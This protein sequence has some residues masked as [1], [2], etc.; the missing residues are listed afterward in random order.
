MLPIGNNNLQ[1]ASL[2]QKPDRYGNISTADTGQSR[3]LAGKVSASDIDLPTSR[4]RAGEMAILPTP[5][6]LWYVSR[7]IPCY[8]IP[9]VYRLNAVSHR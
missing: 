9:L 8:D 4:V 1:Q 6:S 5:T 3:D 2:K 7:C